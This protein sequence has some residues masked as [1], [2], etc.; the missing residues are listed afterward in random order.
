MTDA[1]VPFGIDRARHQDLTGRSHH[2]WWRR[3]ALTM[4]AV[5]P[6][7]GLLSVF[8]QRAALPAPRTRPRRCW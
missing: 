3:M 2:V 7:L 8:G 6:V 5:L 4:V 1:D